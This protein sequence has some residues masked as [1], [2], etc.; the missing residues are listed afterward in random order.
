MAE[1]GDFEAQYWL[2]RIYDAGT[3]LPLDK[4][5]SAYW[6]QKSADEGY[7]P[8]E[9]WVCRDRA[10]LDP[11]ELERCMWRAAEKGVAEAQL[12]L[13]VAFQDHWFGVTDEAEALKWFRKA[14]EHGN[15]DAEATLGM[16]YEWGEGVEQ[17]YV[18]AAYWYR[19]AAEHVPNLGGA[20]QGRN[21]LGNLYED[22]KGVPKDYV[23][24]YMWFSLA[25]SNDNIVYTQ[26][27][28]T[29]DQISSAQKLAADW[30]LQHPDP[31]IY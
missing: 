31:A 22:G 9:Y 29:P 30:K 4:Q 13:G 3:L 15:P 12:W 21:H 26:R 24:A 16:D 2:G 23:Q 14:A 1:S 11:I 19:R 20:G 7:A 17:D 28:M 27:G 10:N 18:K 6:Y 8:A 5:K 25:G